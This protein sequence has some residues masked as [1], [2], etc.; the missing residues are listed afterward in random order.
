MHR[1][2]LYKITLSRFKQKTPADAVVRGMNAFLWAD[3]S[4]HF[5]FLAYL[6]D[7]TYFLLWSSVL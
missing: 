6:L 3:Y 5:F 7:L 2:L 4:A 1:E